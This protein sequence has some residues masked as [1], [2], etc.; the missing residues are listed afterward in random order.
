M[1]TSR[2]VYITEPGKTEVREQKVADPAPHEIQVRCVSNGICMAEVSLFKG[3][4]HWLSYPSVVGHEGLGVVTKVGRDVSHL[5]EGNWVTCMYWAEHWNYNAWSWEIG[6]RLRQPPEWPAAFLAEP[7]DC[8]LRAMRA[9]DMTPGDRVILFGAGYMGLLNV[10]G[11]AQYPLADLVVVDLK[12]KNLDL[13][14]QLGATEVIQA[15]TPQGDARLEELQQEP[16]DL[17]VEAAGAASALE[18]ATPLVRN[19]GRLAIFGWHHGHIPVDLHSWHLKGIRVL[20]AAPEI[21]RDHNVQTMQRAVRLMER[22]L[23]DQT[24][25]ITHRHGVNDVQEAMELANE[26]NGNG[27]IKGVLNFEP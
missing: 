10:M 21:G 3:V 14:R 23:F 25:L 22:G 18:A 6:A 1:V 17:A 27:Y 19:G 16:F 11:L 2:T 15:G 4:S 8:V 5:A 12:P 9:Y 7:V 26:R 13:A 20:N 24:R